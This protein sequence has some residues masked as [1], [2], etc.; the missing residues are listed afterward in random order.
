MNNKLTPEEAQQLMND[1]M[2]ICVQQSSQS[3]GLLE[4]ILDQYLWSLDDSEVDQLREILSK[5]FQYN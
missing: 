2:D 3:V 5:E 1:L 4:V